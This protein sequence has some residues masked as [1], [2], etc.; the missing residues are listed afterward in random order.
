MF[1]IYVFAFYILMGTLLRNISLQNIQAA[2]CTS[3]L[4]AMKG[5]L[6]HIFASQLAKTMH[7]MNVKN[8]IQMHHRTIYLP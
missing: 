7:E 2:H 3:I 6:M 5:F 8:A 4:L 1:N